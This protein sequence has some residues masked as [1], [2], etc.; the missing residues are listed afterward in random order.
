MGVS[1]LQKEL[2]SLLEIWGTVVWFFVGGHFIIHLFI[3]WYAWRVVNLDKAQIA[4]YWPLVASLASAFTGFVTVALIGM[5][6]A[7]SIALNESTS[8]EKFI[9]CASPPTDALSHFCLF[10][11][12]SPRRNVRQHLVSY[13]CVDCSDPS[14]RLAGRLRTAQLQWS[15]HLLNSY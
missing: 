1:Y 13:S 8:L 6:T 4:W 7:H 15:L 3:A 11:S 10:S 9:S 2:S 5:Y 12:P 14:R